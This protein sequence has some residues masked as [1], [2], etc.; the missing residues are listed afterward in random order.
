MNYFVKISINNRIVHDSTGLHI[1]YFNLN[2]FSNIKTS[3]GNE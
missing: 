1:E 3:K 2:L